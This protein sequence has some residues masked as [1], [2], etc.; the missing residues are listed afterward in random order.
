M[1]PY[2]IQ[3]RVCRLWA[4]AQEPQVAIK[5][6]LPCRYEGGDWQFLAAVDSASVVVSSQSQVLIWLSKVRGV[7]GEVNGFDR[8]FVE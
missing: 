3:N 4:E 8:V 7:R 1:H 2:S 5:E 6:L